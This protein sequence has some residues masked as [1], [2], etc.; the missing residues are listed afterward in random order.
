[1]QSALRDLLYLQL[2]G[3]ICAGK[4]IK[5]HSSYSYI[6]V[7]NVYLFVNNRKNCFRGAID[8]EV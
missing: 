3:F 7:R 5:F 4:S 1:M 6:L 2:Y 8:L